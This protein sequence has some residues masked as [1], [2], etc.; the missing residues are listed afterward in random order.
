M[1]RPR[2]RLLLV[3]IAI[4]LLWL[5]LVLPHLLDAWAPVLAFVGIV[6][7]AAWGWGKVAQA[8]GAAAARVE[9]PAVVDADVATEQKLPIVDGS[10]NATSR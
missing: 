10:G 7:A 8:K 4:A 5:G 2:T 6:V 9:E 1:R 3:A